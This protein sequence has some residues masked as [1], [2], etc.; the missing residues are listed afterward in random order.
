MPP[1]GPSAHVKLVGGRDAKVKV[2]A[3][4]LLLEAGIPLKSTLKSPI[5]RLTGVD[6]M[7]PPFGIHSRLL[8]FVAEAAPKATRLL[9]SH[10]P[11]NCEGAGWS[12]AI[13]TT[14]A[15]AASAAERSILDGH[16][17]KRLRGAHGCAS[18]GCAVQTT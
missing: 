15:S 5:E 12:C 2:E 8:G 7:T 6:V 9:P 16:G 3:P 14:S 13:T 4:W 1:V 10:L 17:E 18:A 11:W